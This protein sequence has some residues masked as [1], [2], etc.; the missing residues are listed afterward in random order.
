MSA[1]RD[2]LDTEVSVDVNDNKRTAQSALNW[3]EFDTGVSLI[4]L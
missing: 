4:Q 3:V 2:S 1:S